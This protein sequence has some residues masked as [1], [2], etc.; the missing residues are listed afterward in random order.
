MASDDSTSRLIHGPATAGVRCDYTERDGRELACQ[1]LHEFESLDTSER[2]VCAIE[3]EY[4]GGQPQLNLLL[5]YLD[6]IDSTGS[7]DL[8]AGFTSMLTGYLSICSEGGVPDSQYLEQCMESHPRGT[9][10]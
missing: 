8:K 5:Q 6:S 7:R 1:L 2:S 10:S 9:I 3:A 4:R